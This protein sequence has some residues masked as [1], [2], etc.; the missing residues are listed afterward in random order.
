MTL[1]LVKSLT[2]IL[3]ILL[4]LIFQSLD[5]FIKTIQDLSTHYNGGVKTEI[6]ISYEDRL[7]EEKKILIHDFFEKIAKTCG[8]FKIPFEDY[9][10][11][12]RCEDIHIFKIMSL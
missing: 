9:R 12:F 10:E 5:A 1:L 8:I 6:Y 2:I 7:S 11:D 3:L 4:I